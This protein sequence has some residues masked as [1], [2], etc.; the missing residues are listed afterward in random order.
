[1][2]MVP[3]RLPAIE[4]L[5][6]PGRRLYM[7]AVEGKLVPEFATISRIRREDGDVKGYQ[8]PEVLAHIDEIKRYLESE[9][10]MIPNGIVVAFDRMVHFEPTVSN[11]GSTYARPGELIIPVDPELLEEAK[12]GFIVDGQ[13]RLAAIREAAINSFPICVTAFITSDVRE[14]TEQFILV[15]ST[16]PLPKGLIYELLPG[17]ETTLPSLLQRRRF[18]AYLLDRLNRD[19]DSPLRGLIQTP[20]TPEGVIKDNSLLRMLENS[21]SDGVLYRLRGTR[22][23]SEAADDMLSVLKAFWCAVRE[24]FEEAWG[25]PARRSRMMHGAGIIGLGFLMDAIAERQRVTGV[26]GLH[27]FSEDL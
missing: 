13:Q 12:P 26:P 8:R 9:S 27:E 1:M 22:P 16:K 6:S 21:L 19:A 24:V 11:N 4:V 20:T 15:N 23:E 14:Q 7:F 3:M 5:Q 2:P 17:T 25:L 18:P 10:P